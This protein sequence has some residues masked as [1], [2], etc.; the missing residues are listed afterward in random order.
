MTRTEEQLEELYLP[1]LLMQV[2]G[3]KVF[4]LFLSLL[5]RTYVFPAYRNLPD[6]EMALWAYWADNAFIPMNQEIATLIQSKIDLIDGKMPSSF[7]RFIAYHQA[8]KAEQERW[9]RE[10]G[11]Y[12]HP[13]NFPGDFESEILDRIGQLSLAVGWAPKFLT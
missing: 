7:R 9:I 6:G 4:R 11:E 10:G 2:R 1:L 12:R 5:G 13:G 3:K 8:F